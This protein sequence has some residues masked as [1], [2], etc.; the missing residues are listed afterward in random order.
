MLGLATKGRQRS[1]ENGGCCHQKQHAIHSFGAHFCEVVFDP[2][3][4]HLR[5]TRWLTVIDGGRMISLKSARN[6]IRLEKW[7]V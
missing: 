1:G 6:Q 5:V 3:I 2:D 4:V 7:L